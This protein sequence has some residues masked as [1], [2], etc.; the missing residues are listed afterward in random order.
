[1]LS[2]NQ[3]H[4]QDDFEY[5]KCPL[6]GS[7]NYKEAYSRFHYVDDDMGHVKITNVICVKCGFMYMNP[8]FKEEALNIHYCKDSSGD[9]YHETY[10]DSRHGV[11]TTERKNFI[12]RYLTNVTP[13]NYLDIGCGQGDLLRN[14]DLASWK[15]YGL[16]P[17]AAP[18]RSS[19]DYI[20][21]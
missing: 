21:S 15:K 3:P 12:G 18:L 2:T 13:G 6:C 14:L 1:M 8:R 9:V 4:N 19:Q 16:E 20:Y 11:L 5:I 17:S 10:S 7:K